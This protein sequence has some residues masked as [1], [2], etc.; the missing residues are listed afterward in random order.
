MAVQTVPLV[1][2]AGRPQ[3]WRSHRRLQPRDSPLS[4]SAIPRYQRSTETFYSIFDIQKTHAKKSIF[5]K[6]SKCVKS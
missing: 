2:V 1:K 4:K 5:G 3:A 6:V